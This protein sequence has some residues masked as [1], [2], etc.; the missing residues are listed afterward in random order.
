MPRF[1]NPFP[2]FDFQGDAI[3]YGELYFYNSGTNTPKTT[4]KNAAETIPNTNPVLLDASGRVPN[5]FFT[6]TAKVVLKT[7]PDAE[8][9]PNQVVWEADPVGAQVGLNEPTAPWTEQTIYQKNDI[10]EGAD[11]KLYLST[12]GNN[13]G[14][15][16]A[17]GVPEWAFI[18]FLQEWTSLQTFQ[19]NNFCTYEGTIYRSLVDGD[20][21]GNQPDTSPVQWE[22]V[23]LTQAIADTIYLKQANNL[24]DLDN[25][26]TA[27]ANLDLTKQS[28]AFDSTAGVLLTPGAFGLGVT[29]QSQLNSDPNTTEKTGFSRLGNTNVPKLNSGAGL[30]N[31]T[32]DDGTGNT[33]NK[34][35][36]YL[37]ADQTTKQ[38]ELFYRG[39]YNNAYQDWVGVWDTVNFDLGGAGYTGAQ[40]VTII[41]NADTQLTPTLGNVVYHANG[42][43]VTA[44][45]AATAIKG[46]KDGD[47][48]KSA[49]SVVSGN[50][51]NNSTTCEFVG[52]SGGSAV[53]NKPPGYGNNIAGM[54]YKY[55]SS[56]WGAQIVFDTIPGDSA[57]FRCLQNNVWGS[58][59]ELYHTGNAN[60]LTIATSLSP[61]TDN[62]RSL[63]E[64]SKRYSVVYAGTGTINT[65]DAREKTE[66]SPL[67]Q[68]E[69]NCAQ[70]L[71]D[72][73]GSYKWLESINLKGNDARIHI[74]LT[75]QKA[76][77]IFTANNLDAMS[78]GI[79][80]HDQWNDE[81]VDHEA[82]YEQVAVLDDDGNETGEYKNGQLTKDAWTEQVQVAGDRYGFR[83]DQL[84]MFILAG[85]NAKQKQLE[86]VI[87][88][89]ITRLNEAGL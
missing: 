68:D 18:Q 41:S 55:S 73:I 53:A 10:V 48:G 43:G 36:I 4:Y 32:I 80:C 50:D 23:T 24:S 16:P 27:R 81:F 77:E 75:V 62:N 63:G 69:I 49:T 82:Q 12:V 65:S 79:I 45:Q 74:G 78:Y 76:I 2:E 47:I 11:G 28:S 15:N 6:G 84:A 56:N 26:V 31:I 7:S 29:T 54:T 40:A 85:L 70:Q 21:L 30:L 5:I 66:V 35:Q 37:G 67:T 34:A 17:L 46:A 38:T 9:N 58:W 60:N 72:E 71:G 8:I 83:Y 88:S 44:A 33:L 22:V 51:L 52:T 39:E 86:S 14:N 19:L 13:Q 57:S 59:Q 42:N 20:N 3:A 64:A 61:S 25:V 87:D 1:T 89:L